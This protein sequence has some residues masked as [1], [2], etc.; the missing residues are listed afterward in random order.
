MHQPFPSHTVHS[1]R[2][3]LLLEVWSKGGR[4][5]LA[6]MAVC[7]VTLMAMGQHGGKSGFAAPTS[8]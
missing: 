7:E 1:F 2:D 4:E 3:C 5:A 8:S 6:G